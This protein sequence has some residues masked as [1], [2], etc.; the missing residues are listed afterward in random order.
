MRATVSIAMVGW[1]YFLW[2]AL[3]SSVRVILS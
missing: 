2:L 1:L 3:I